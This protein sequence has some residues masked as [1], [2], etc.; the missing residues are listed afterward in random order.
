MIKKKIEDR[1]YKKDL[2]INTEDLENEWVTQPSNYM[3]YAEALADAIY[4]RDQIKT[5]V[6]FVESQLDNDIVKTWEQ[7]YTKFPS[8]QMRRN[9]IVLSEKYQK[10]IAKLDKANHNVNLLTGARNAFEHK[11]NALGNLVTMNVS[12]FHSEPKINKTARRSH[13]GLKKGA[14]I[15][16]RG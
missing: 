11:K 13:V 8:E 4:E 1:S 15:K 10:V 3:Y 16:K 14:V 5:E 12:G 7:H 6:E 2:E 9:K